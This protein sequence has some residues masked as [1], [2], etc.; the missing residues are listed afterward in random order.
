MELRRSQ[1]H[2]ERNQYDILIMRLSAR[3]PGSQL[4][5]AIN[6]ILIIVDVPGG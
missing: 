3:L 1:L 4:S 6:Y 5:I 2:C